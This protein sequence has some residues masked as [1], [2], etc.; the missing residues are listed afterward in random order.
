MINGDGTQKG[1]KNMVK[2]K[3]KA[4]TRK[5]KYGACPVLDEP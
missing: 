5:I 1:R 2:N 4:V 3:N